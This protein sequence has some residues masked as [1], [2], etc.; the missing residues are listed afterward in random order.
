MKQTPLL[1][2]KGKWVAGPWCLR[3]YAESADVDHS[4]ALGSVSWAGSSGYDVTW[5]DARDQR[6]GIWSALSFVE[7]CKWFADKCGLDAPL[8]GSYSEL[9][10]R[11]R[12]GMLRQKAWRDERRA[13]V[14]AFSWA[15]SP[16]R[17]YLGE[18]LP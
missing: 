9:D 3:L 14:P 5:R 18:V 6:C 13:T 11:G 12:A 4:W 1:L 2:P 15:N 8:R 16:E 7:T 10:D 17:A